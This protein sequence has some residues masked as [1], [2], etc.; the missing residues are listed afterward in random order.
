MR[1]TVGCSKGVQLE[2][3]GDPQ[4]PSRG[5]IWRSQ[6]R[7]AKGFCEPQG[8]CSSRLLVG[9]KS[10]GLRNSSFQVYYGLKL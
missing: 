5:C 1:G 8:G 4:G 6:W 7:A 2:V 3:F 10:P 9:L